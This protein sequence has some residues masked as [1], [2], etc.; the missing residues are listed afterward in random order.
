MCGGEAVLYTCYIL[1]RVPHKKLDQIPY[2]LWKGYASN[3]SFLRVWGCLPK[4]PLPNFKCKSICS[5][6]F[7]S[8]FIG[9][10]QNSVVYKLC[11]WKTHLLVSPGMQNSLSMLSLWKEMSLLLCIKAYLCTLSISSNGVRDSVDQPRWSKRPRVE[12]S[13]GPNFLTNF[14]IEN[15][16]VNLLSDEHVSTLSN[17]N[18]KLMNRLWDL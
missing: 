15:I 6:I 12:T 11:Y 17:K 10:A 16:A 2:K 13:F 7:D 18:Q 3:M 4:V 1:N 14:L 5:K 9:Y 8:M